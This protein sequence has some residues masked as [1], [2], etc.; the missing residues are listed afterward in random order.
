MTPVCAADK[1]QQYNPKIFSVVSIASH[2]SFNKICIYNELTS[3]TIKNSKFHGTN[4]D[5][6]HTKIYLIQTNSM[7]EYNIQNHHWQ[8]SPF[9][10]IALL[11]IFSQIC[12][13]VF[14]PLDL[15]TTIIF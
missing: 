12:Y 14:T 10:A 2:V 8:N 6:M 9:G 4:V 11:R 7:H 3:R 13:P 5:N 15:T 1:H